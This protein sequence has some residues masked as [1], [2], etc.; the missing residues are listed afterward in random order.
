MSVESGA[1]FHIREGA[2]EAR[3][4]ARRLGV[5]ACRP[6]LALGRPNSRPGAAE[7][8]SGRADSRG[9]ED[10]QGASGGIPHLPAWS[11]ECGRP[12]SRR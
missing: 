4:G 7:K 2:D 3:E 12:L 10:E 6:A 5:G 11:R 9:C 8:R 1:P